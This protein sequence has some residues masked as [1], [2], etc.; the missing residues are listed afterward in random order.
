M[1]RG[2]TWRNILKCC[3]KEGTE[4]VRHFRRL[5]HI[6]F[7]EKGADRGVISFN[8]IVHYPEDIEMQRELSRR[9]AIVHAQAIMQKVKSLSCPLEQKVA[10]LDA[11]EKYIKSRDGG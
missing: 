4:N 3:Q 11:V 6:Q 7:R 1:Q 8:I 2:T 10:L 9:V 5:I